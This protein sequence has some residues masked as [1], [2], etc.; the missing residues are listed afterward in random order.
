[1]EMICGDVAIVPPQKFLE[2]AKGQLRPIRHINDM[3]YD[4]M[5]KFKSRIL[6]TNVGH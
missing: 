3:I 1:M 6:R 2:R 5:T 4:M